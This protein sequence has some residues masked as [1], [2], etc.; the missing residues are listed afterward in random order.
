MILVD[1]N[2][3]IEYLRSPDGPIGRVLNALLDR[4]EAAIAGVVFAEVLQGTRKEE[5]F[6]RVER[7]LQSATYIETIRSAWR[8]AARLSIELQ[9]QGQPV[10]LTDLVIAAVALEGDHQVF[11][12]DQHFERIPGLRLYDWKGHLGA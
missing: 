7:G 9:R 12:S 2:V 10:P 6:A 1:S 11:T 3:W 8:R 5:D 4:R